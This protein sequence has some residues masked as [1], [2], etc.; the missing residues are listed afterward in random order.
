VKTYVDV[1]V[2]STA[3]T[4]AGAPISDGASKGTFRFTPDADTQFDG[5]TRFWIERQEVGKSRQRISSIYTF[6][7]QP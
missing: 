3:T 7:R 2:F 6:K 4:G 1:L 5:E